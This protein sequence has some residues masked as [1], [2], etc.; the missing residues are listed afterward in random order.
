MPQKKLSPEQIRLIAE[1]LLPNF[2]PKDPAENSLSFHFTAEGANI[3]LS[4][5]RKGNQWELI[6]FKQVE[7]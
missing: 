4:F 3:R 5:S 6:D 1:N 2:I 7:E